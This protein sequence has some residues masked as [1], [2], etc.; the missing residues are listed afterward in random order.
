MYCRRLRLDR[1]PQLLFIRA[2]DALAEDMTW[3]T[4]F[5][6]FDGRI[7]RKQWWLATLALLTVSLALSILVNP[8]AYFSE[9]EGPTA[10]RGPDTLLSLA[11]L[12]PETAVT[13]KRFNDRDWPQWLPYAYALFVAAF[14]MADHHRLIF[15]ADEPTTIDIAIIIGGFAIALAVIVDN[16]MLRGTVG[17]N[18]YGED[19]LGTDEITAPVRVPHREAT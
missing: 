14:T 19:P 15:V 3:K 1:R 16:G 13:V 18:R 5:F 7:G 2:L 8:S 12:I 10:A 4:L 6:D 11:F 9:S 17:P